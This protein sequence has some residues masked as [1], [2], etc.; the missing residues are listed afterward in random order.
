MTV[1]KK[2]FTHADDQIFKQDWFR[3]FD[4]ELEPLSEILWE[5]PI[6][7]APSYPFEEDPDLPHHYMTTRYNGLKSFLQ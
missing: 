2:E 4:R 1:G 5:F 6:V 3:K 7:F